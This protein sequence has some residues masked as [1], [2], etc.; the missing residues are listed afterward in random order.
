MR[1]KWVALVAG[2][3]AIAVLAIWGTVR[4]VEERRGRALLEDAKRE[5]DAVRYGTAQLRLTDLLR[6][7]PG[8]DEAR[9]YLGVCEQGRRRAQAALDA[10]E[11]VPDG[12]PWAG[13]S[14][15][16]RSRIE[17]DRGR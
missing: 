9:Y 14:A 6:R 15:V 10:F 2:A 1:P 3:C 13:W 11:Q 7:R 16:R 12:S 5:L 8:W 17:M 4:A